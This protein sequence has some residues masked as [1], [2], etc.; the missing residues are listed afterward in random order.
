ME[1]IKNFKQYI[2]NDS[3]MNIYLP[4][5]WHGFF[6]ALTMSMIEMNTVLPTL[7]TRLTSN[8]IAFGALYSIMLGAPVIFN[9]VFSRYMQKFEHKKKF[10]L[11]GI[12]LRAGSFAGM[13]VV[14]LIFAKSNPLVA[15]LSFY[16]LIFTFSLSGGFAGIAYTDMVGKLLPSSKRG[17]FYAAKQFFNGVGALTGGFMVAWI[18]KPG[19]LNFPLNY[20]TSFSIGAIGLFLGAVG[21]WILKEPSS[22]IPKEANGDRWEFLKDVLSIIKGDK[23]FL[24]FIII[25]NMTSFSLMI[26]PFYMV[27]IKNS[28]TNYMGYLGIFVIAQITGNIASN[29]LWAIIS[30]RFGSQAVVRLCIFIGGLLPIIAI[31]LKPFG[32]SWYI[33]LFVFIGFIS[34]G[35]GIGFDLFFLDIAP[36]EKRTVYLG[37][38]GTL[39]ILVIL[40]PLA[41]GIFIRFF[42]FYATFILVSIAM[43]TAFFMA[44]AYKSRIN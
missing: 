37:I 13:A 43:F 10:L 40:L 18:F 11:F 36:E 9:L 33:I 24:K 35:R 20:V 12:Y 38:R 32:I 29:F 42:G 3:Y 2:Y 4:F 27:F 15:L 26:L 7:I 39:N 21:F 30:K 16:F 34:S 41:G 5:I 23:G 22:I 14:T 1:K 28:F 31:F 8:T 6:I 44:G 25:E 17:G 19:S